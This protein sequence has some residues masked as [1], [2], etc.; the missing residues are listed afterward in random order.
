MSVIDKLEILDI[1]KLLV[2]QDLKYWGSDLQVFNGSSGWH[3]D[4]FSYPSF[5]KVGIYLHQ[6]MGDVSNFLCIPGTHNRLSSYAIGAGMGLEW[7]K[8]AGFK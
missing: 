7:P 1:A 3:R 6:E 5:L 2:G 8:G 4:I